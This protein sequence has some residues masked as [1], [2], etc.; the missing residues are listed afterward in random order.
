MLYF[1]LY[2]LVDMYHISVL[3]TVVVRTDTCHFSSFIE[4][5]YKYPYRSELIYEY[6]EP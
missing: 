2:L 6:D 5:K 1:D 4:H 3:Y